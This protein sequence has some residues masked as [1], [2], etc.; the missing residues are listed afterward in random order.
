MLYFWGKKCNFYGFQ[1][2]AATCIL[3]EQ[4]H[5]VRDSL[6]SCEGAN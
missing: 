5:V 2:G 4:L 6:E 1:E 3:M